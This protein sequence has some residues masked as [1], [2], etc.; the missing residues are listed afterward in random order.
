[1][2][3]KSYFGPR[4]LRRNYPHQVQGVRPGRLSHVGSPALSLMLKW[5]VERRKGK[6]EGGSRIAKRIVGRLCQTPTCMTAFH[7]NALQVPSSELW[8]ALGLWGRGR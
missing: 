4:S 2:A 1:M 3:D 8:F 7:R 6:F 5:K